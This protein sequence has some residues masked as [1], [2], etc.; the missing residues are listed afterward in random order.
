MIVIG[1]G[2]HSKVVCSY[3][4]PPPQTVEI[5]EDEQILNVKDVDKDITKNC[6]IVAI[7]DN[8]VRKHL[9]ELFIKS[10]YRP[11]DVTGI[12]VVYSSYASKSG[13]SKYGVYVSELSSGTFV[14]SNATINGGVKIGNNVI[15]NTGAIIEHDCIIHDHAFIGPGAVLCGNVEVGEGAFIGAGVIVVPKVK[16]EPW[17]IINAGELVR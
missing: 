16:I 5:F 1:K 17:R 12:G 6:F 8:K 7:G 11:V 4:N 14:G 13:A 15:I 2:G 3:I 9:Y 10:K